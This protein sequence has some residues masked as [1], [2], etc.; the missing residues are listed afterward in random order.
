MSYIRSAAI[1]LLQRGTITIS[2]ASLTATATVTS[3]DTAKAL[4]NFEGFS[5]SVDT[6]VIPARIS[7][8]NATTITATRGTA[9]NTPDTIVSYELVEYY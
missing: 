9:T 8:T 2:G 3:V 6:Q 4:L 5:A 1:K 7:L